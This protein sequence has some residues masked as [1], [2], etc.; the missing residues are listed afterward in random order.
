MSTRALG[1]LRVDVP[2]RGIG[3]L[4]GNHIPLSALKSRIMWRMKDG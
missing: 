2:A 3:D 1:H 4:G